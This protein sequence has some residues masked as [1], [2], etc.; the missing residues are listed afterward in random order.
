VISDEELAGTMVDLPVSD[1][2]DIHN[3]PHRIDLLNTTAKAEGRR[4]VASSAKSPEDT[5]P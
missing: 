1:R 3:K 2:I 5:K 4:V